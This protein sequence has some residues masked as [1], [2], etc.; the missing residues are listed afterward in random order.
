M[1][2][3]KKKILIVEDDPTLMRSLRDVFSMEGF[4]LLTAG[5]GEAA[6]ESIVQNSPDLVLLD[7][8]LP[9]MDGMT[10]LKKL[11]ADARFA[12]LPV[13]MLTNKDDIDTVGESLEE[14]VQDF[15]V[16]HEWK[17]E[18][19]VQRAKERLAGKR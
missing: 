3:E 2:A 19:I 4:D 7:I 10:L 12:Q 16:K 17:L 15:L 14:G 1:N 13:I 6:F 18:A 9:K 5:D 8:I 11:R